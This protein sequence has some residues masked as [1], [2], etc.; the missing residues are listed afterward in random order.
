MGQVEPGQTKTVTITCRT[1]AVG[2]TEDI[3]YAFIS[4][5]PPEYGLG[6]PL[7]ISVDSVLPTIN[8]TDY[9]FMFKEQFIVDKLSDFVTP[10]EINEHSLFIKDENTIM[11]N[12]DC[13]DTT[14]SARIHLN[15]PS[16]VSADVTAK[17]VLKGDAQFSVSPPKIEILPYSHG[18]FEIKFTPE[19]MK[20][21]SGTLELSLLL[22]AGFKTE[23]AIFNLRGEGKVPQI[24]LIEPNITDELAADLVFNPTLIG[25]ITVRPI[26]FENTGEFPCKVLVEI[27]NDEQGNFS[28]VID[29]IKQLLCY[30]NNEDNNMLHQTSLTLIPGQ[31]ANVG[32]KYNPVK[33][34]E[35]YCK[36]RL[37]VIH[38]PFEVHVINVA[39]DS[40]TEDVILEGLETTFETNPMENANSESRISIDLN[41]HCTLNS[42]CTNYVMDFGNSF[43]STLQKKRFK[44]INQ[45]T[46]DTYKF[47][48]LVI[49][50]VSFI[51]TLGH[52]R[53]GAKK[54]VIATFLSSDPVSYVKVSFF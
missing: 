8:F 4:E 11:F 28:L 31:R 21:Y 38:N 41:S 52:L 17:I 18:S 46:T 25:K 9:E 54:E 36:V 15:N 1:K 42:Y 51:P 45:S 23:S 19:L 14:A 50:E 44:I 53:P 20:T 34:G 29:E 13:I 22:P 27:S 26:I 5:C 37:H 16:L 2:I 35:D 32:I 47:Q 3:F 49:N 12:N 48:F 40:F 39:A 7:N 30:Y 24:T 43:L 6:I 10:K 33:L